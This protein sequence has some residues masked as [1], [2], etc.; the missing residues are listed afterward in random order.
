MQTDDANAIITQCIRHSEETSARSRKA[1]TA[2][3]EIRSK[4]KIK[5]QIGSRSELKK[6]CTSGNREDS[7]VKAEKETKRNK[8]R[9]NDN[10]A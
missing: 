6:R 7:V 2:M 3:V 10:E 4:E 9:E 5:I 1:E 8:H